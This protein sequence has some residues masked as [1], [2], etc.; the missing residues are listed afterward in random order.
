M[1]FLLCL[2]FNFYSSCDFAPLF[3]GQF[4]G[5]RGWGSLNF[6]CG[7]GRVVTLLI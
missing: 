2:N 7:P 1:V 3:W 5:G 4:R 6:E